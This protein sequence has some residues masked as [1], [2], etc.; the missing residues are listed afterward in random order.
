MA[1]GLTLPSECKAASCT[2]SYE[3]KTQ[4]SK[5]NEIDQ[6]FVGG[7]VCSSA[8]QINGMMN[9]WRVASL[10]SASLVVLE[11]CVLMYHTRTK[12]TGSYEIWFPFMINELHHHP[13]NILIF[14]LMSS[15][16]LPLDCFIFGVLS[17]DG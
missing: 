15:P 1:S 12:Q 2:R 9:S 13:Q 6:M 5:L 14:V 3:L 8:S 10:G 17:F 16:I 7:P 4:R 11:M